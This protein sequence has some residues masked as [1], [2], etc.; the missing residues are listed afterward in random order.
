[1]AAGSVVLLVL[2]LIARLSTHVEYP[3]ALFGAVRSVE[4]NLKLS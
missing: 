1:M 4:G 3:F 2:K